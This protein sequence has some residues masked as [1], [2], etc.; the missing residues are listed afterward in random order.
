MINETVREAF[1]R[2]LAKFQEVLEDAV[3]ASAAA[4][5]TLGSARMGWCSFLHARAVSNA[6]SIVTLIQSATDQQP[7]QQALDHFA[8]ASIGRTMM[9]TCVVVAYLSDLSVDMERWK[10][11]K[12]AIDLH[13]ATHR[14]R[15]FK[16]L[17]E[18]FG[19]DIA[20][21][22][23]EFPEARTMLRKRMRENAGFSKLSRDDRDNLISGRDFL[24]G[25]IDVV[26]QQVGGD[27]SSFKHA[28]SYFSAFVHSTPVSFH[29]AETHKI[30]FST[31]STFQYNLCQAVMS[32][33]SPWLRVSADSIRGLI[34]HD[35]LFELQSPYASP[36]L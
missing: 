28:H 35:P 7:G 3:T 21:M 23:A 1:D 14:T 5:G 24:I 4:N 25:G 22:M 33:T 6:M 11:M 26:V 19:G 29:R 36:Q 2:D 18:E 9:E 20:A 31:I 32:Y 12:A 17:V 10:L 15:I 30:D 13:D 27:L 16:P 34:A 8:I